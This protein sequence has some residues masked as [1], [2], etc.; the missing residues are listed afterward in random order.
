MKVTLDLED[1]GQMIESTVSDNLE[2]VINNQVKEYVK[3]QIDS[4]AKDVIS[5]KVSENFQ[6]FVDEYI[7]T[8][9]IK[10]G[11]NS[12][13]NDEEPQEFTVEQYIKYELKKR[14]ES[15]KLKVK[16]KDRYSDYSEVTF[17]EYINRAFSPDDLIKGELDEFMDDIRK[18]INKTMQETFDKSTKDMLSSTV[19]SILTANDTY[20]KIENNIKCI[21]DK[22]N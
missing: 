8:T 4:L 5:E 22:G 17:E 2:T 1:L 15:K 7:A 9:K 19:L 13:W 14:L 3:E 10:V 16:S 6:R 20:R 21:A 18:K 12:Y 11:G